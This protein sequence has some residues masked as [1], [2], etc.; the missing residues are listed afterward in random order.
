MTCA[1]DEL[2]NQLK[3]RMD[4][5]YPDAVQLRRQLHQCPEPGFAE[6]ETSAMV[7]AWL[8]KLGLEV[9]TGIAKT[10]IKAI[11]RGQKD[12]PVIG[13]RA[14]MDALPITENTGLPFQSQHKGFMHACG[15][16]GHMTNVLL[17]AALLAEMRQDIPGTVVFVFQPCEEG[18]PP[19]QP[20]GAERMITEGVLKNPD[21][22]AM[23]GLHILPGIPVG[24]IGICSGPIMANV[25]TIRIKIFGK[26]SHG[27]FPHQG[28]DAIY[29]ASA[30]IMQF[31]TLIS[32]YQ[33][34]T[35][36][37][38]LSIGKING[39]VRCNVIADLVEM[40][41]TMRTFSHETQT[42]ISQGI[43]KI[44]KG[45][46]IAHGCKY[47]FDL[48]KDAP[49]VNNDPQLTAQ[50][51]PLFQK[52]LGD[53]QVQIIKPLTIAED[54]AFYSKHIPSVF[55]MLGNGPSSALHTP[56]FSIHEDTLKIGP[57]LFAYSAINWLKDHKN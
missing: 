38:V 2:I 17:T 52:I 1:N 25:D 28:I 41:G 3:L 9:E 23:L 13:I 16:D 57:V 55:F 22:Q 7:A 10:G 19:G 37:A 14:D 26:A 56:E 30:A 8:K 49:F 24:S 33:D 48:Q 34:P 46:S 50:V 15:H 42:S 43:E 27:A 47:S 18:P 54:F 44:L 32:R 31:Q 11:L 6:T 4:E 39:G 29:I 40:E 20:G 21:I 35:D 53:T 45:L 12:S 5:L 36:P 51:I